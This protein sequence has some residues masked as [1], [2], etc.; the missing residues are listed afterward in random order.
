MKR[1]DNVDALRAVLVD[2]RSSGQTIGLVPTMGNVHAGHLSLVS[3]VRNQAD[4]VVAS[5]FVNPLQFGVN[6]DFARYPR[7][8]KEDSE[9][10]H[11]AGVDLLYTPTVNSVYPSGSPPRVALRLSGELT[12]TLEGAYRPGHFDGVATVVLILFNQVQPD[13]AVFGEKDWQQLAVIRQM[14]SD[15]SLQIMV[16]GR[17]TVR[18]ADG[19]AMSSRNQY[20]SPKERT[21]ASNLYS[22]LTEVASALEDGRRD[23]ASLCERQINLLSRLGF[24]IQYMEI[25][26]P[27]LQ[28]PEECDQEFVVL[29]AGHLG[30]TRL[31]DCLHV[32][33]RAGVAD[34]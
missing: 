7:T 8:L 24:Q 31:I 25:R 2:A 33:A 21:I 23:F 30:K 32:D 34:L 26:R 13:L 15:L 5:I 14:V 17:P 9:K 11:A 6:E 4:L 1:V 10:L 27:D 19:L 20:L 12:E 18:E 22:S 29:V 28:M 3:W 16:T